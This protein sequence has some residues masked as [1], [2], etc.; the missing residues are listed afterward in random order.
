MPLDQ[1]V[2]GSDLSAQCYGTQRS[3]TP[4]ARAQSTMYMASHESTSALRVWRWPDAD[5]APASSVVSD[6]SNGVAASYLNTGFSCPR[7]NI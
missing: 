7:N 6:T 2:A 4:V 1:L 5:G 3:V